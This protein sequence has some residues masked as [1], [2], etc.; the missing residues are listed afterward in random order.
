MRA[1]QS[2]II[3][4]CPENRWKNTAVSAVKM[5][6]RDS[7][8]GVVYKQYCTALEEIKAIPGLKEQVDELRKLN[9]QIQAEGD[10]INLYDAIDDVDSKMDE[11]CR[12]PE[13]NRFLEAELT[14]CR[15][16]QSIDASIHQGIQLDIPDL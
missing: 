9:Y 2:A 4:S 3:Q 6:I 12:I 1:C 5:C 16:L 15:Q 7:K 13:V 11:L 14:L 10:E 8:N